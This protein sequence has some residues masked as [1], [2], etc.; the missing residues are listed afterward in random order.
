MCIG[1][2]CCL[3]LRV[4]N[5]TTSFFALVCPAAMKPIR[6]KINLKWSKFPTVDR[7]AVHMNACG[8]FIFGNAFEILSPS[9]WNYIYLRFQRAPVVPFVRSPGELPNERAPC[10]GL[11]CND[12]NSEW[13]RN[14]RDD[15]MCAALPYMLNMA[16][17][18]FEVV[19]SNMCNGNGTPFEQIHV[20]RRLCLCCVCSPG[21]G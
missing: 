10:E 13:K 19:R 11:T 16:R 15:W 14:E 9:R 6:I 1:T 21:A 18:E 12:F 5:A 7:I 8:A 20:E 4:A 2:A 3:P 17:I